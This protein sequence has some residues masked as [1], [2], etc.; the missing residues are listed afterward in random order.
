MRQLIR[1]GIRQ[2]LRET[3]NQDSFIHFKRFA[4]SILMLF[5][6]LSFSCSFLLAQVLVHTSVGTLKGINGNHTVSF[7]GIPYTKPPV[8]NLRWTAPSPPARWTGVRLAAQPSPACIQDVVDVLLPWTGE[9]MVHSAT[10]EDCLYL[11]VWTPFDFKNKKLPVY[12]YFHGGGFNQGSGAVTVYDGENLARKGIVI[13]TVNYRLGA[14]GFMA[15]PELTAESPH[16]ASGNYGLLDALASLHWVRSNIAA[17]GGDP[18]KVSIGGQSAGAAVVH[19]LMASPLGIG[20]FRGAEAASG[21]GLGRPMKGLAAAEKEGVAYASSKGAH[22]LAD[23]RKL[24]ATSFII[25]PKDGIPFSPIVDGWVLPDSPLVLTQQ[26]KANNVALLTGMDADEGSAFPN[27]GKLSA[28]DWHKQVQ[29]RYLDLAGKFEALYPAADDQSA[30]EVE[31]TSARDR[32]RASMYLWCA[33]AAQK[34]NSRRYTYYFNQAIPWPEHPEYAAFHSSELVYVF[35]NLDKLRRPFT[36]VDR[37]VEAQASGFLI[38]F[39]RSGNP[40]GPGL[41]VW[42]EVSADN[43]ATFEIGETSQMR[44]LM[45]SEKLAFWTEYLESPQGKNA[46]MF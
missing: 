42:K 2:I 6:L 39:I 27:Y 40:N 20:L 31:K 8:G 29:E 10:S 44:P 25:G 12:V 33:R 37:R 14:L 35:G 17:F 36:E 45:S 15:H 1:A 28:A 46:P 13:V 7:K 43:P 16:R 32:G 19:D 26:G 18:Q 24:P 9:F 41:P 22:T 30:G 34:L 4:A 5:S 21:T 38:N 3:Q 11:N 23:L